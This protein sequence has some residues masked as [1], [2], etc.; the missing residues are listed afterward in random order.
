VVIVGAACDD[1]DIHRWVYN[2]L[3]MMDSWVVSMK[4]REVGVTCM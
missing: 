4:C 2:K 1:I 3:K